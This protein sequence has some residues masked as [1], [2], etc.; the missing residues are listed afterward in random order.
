[1]TAE[2]YVSAYATAKICGY[3]GSYDDFK[4][5]YD[6]YYLE[7]INS[8]PNEKPQLAEIKATNN[9]FRSPKRF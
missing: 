8:L 4:K 5:L 3:N 2:K 1:M 7:I 9:P 6:Q